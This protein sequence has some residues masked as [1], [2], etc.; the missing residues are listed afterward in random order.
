MAY[1]TQ[2]LLVLCIAWSGA[3]TRIFA[4]VVLGIFQAPKF[5]SGRHTVPANGLRPSISS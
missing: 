5:A 3:R 4:R 2:V 1:G